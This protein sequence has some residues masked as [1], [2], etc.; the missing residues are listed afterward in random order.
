MRVELVKGAFGYRRLVKSDKKK[1]ES[2]LK[3]RVEWIC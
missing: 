3:G 1:G 2:T